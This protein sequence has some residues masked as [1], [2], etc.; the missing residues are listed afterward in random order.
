MTEEIKLLLEKV[1]EELDTIEGEDLR[2]FAH[3]VDNDG[4]Y[5]IIEGEYVPDHLRNGAITKLSSI[6]RQFANMIRYK[7]NEYLDSEES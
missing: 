4:A 3:H 2:D 5:V 1:Q 6:V 7:S